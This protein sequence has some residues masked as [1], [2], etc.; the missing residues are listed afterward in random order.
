MKY[1]TIALFLGVITTRDIELEEARDAVNALKIHVSKAGQAAIEKEAKDV[2]Y[3]AKAIQHTRPVR[4]LKSS[5]ERWGHS[6]EV[7]HIKKLD[8]AFLASP[9]GKQLIQ[10]WKDVGK[11]LEENVYENSTGIHIPNS[12]LDK[13]GDEL[14]DVAYQYKTLEGTGWEKAY[15][16][17]YDAAFTNK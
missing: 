8:K 11:V 5:L 14:D 7:L 3:T 4:N 15:T 17:A 6:K 12:A 9:K 16:K 1:F 13:I 10:E 2:K